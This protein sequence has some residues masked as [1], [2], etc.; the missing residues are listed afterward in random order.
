MSKKRQENEFDSAMRELGDILN[1]VARDVRN[2]VSAVMPELTTSFQQIGNEIHQA[3]SSAQS[4]K[5]KNNENK[6]R[7]EKN[8]R[9]QKQ[10]KRA[11]NK[12]FLFGFFSIFFLI[13][14]F[15]FLVGF[16]ATVFYGSVF[17]E[18]FSRH[19]F[20][21]VSILGL[22]SLISGFLAKIFHSRFG[23][24]RKFQK[25][26]DIIGDR[27]VCSISELSIGVSE[28]TTKTKRQLQKL[29]RR[30]DLP[31]AYY[32]EQKELLFMDIEA[33]R[34]SVAQQDVETPPVQVTS[35]KT[36]SD[37]SDKVD[38]GVLESGYKIV[39]QIMQYAAMITDPATSNEAKLIG[40]VSKK[41]LDHVHTH[42]EKLTQ[43]KKFLDY[44]LPTTE[45]LL[46]TYATCHRDHYSGQN[47]DAIRSNIS[48]ILKTIYA[49][50][51]RL[52]DSLFQEEALDI[53]TDITVLKS[54]LEQEGFL[55]STDTTE[56]ISHNHI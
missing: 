56:T 5:E 55:G 13:L 1:G 19:I 44:Y 33:F 32:N 7:K 9:I 50:F 10:K 18:L 14:F 11:K 49:A 36:S 30:G 41:I 35:E 23:L 54:L 3:F 25:Y 37:T 31:Y 34:Q 29:I 39:D 26:L 4:S 53:S 48:G 47:I 42:P 38:R 6:V 45:K 8:T 24:M 21:A 27:T 46:Q 51:V 17:N 20:V 2:S 43:I 40:S 22:F 28:S 52:L 12:A 16:G 15:C